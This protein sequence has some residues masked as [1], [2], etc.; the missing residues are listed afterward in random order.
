MDKYIEKMILVSEE[1]W[2]LLLKNE[3]QNETHTKESLFP[4]E[5]KSNADKSETD[6]ESIVNGN[7]DKQ[8]SPP[9]IPEEGIS[10]IDG[11]S[12]EDESSWDRKRKKRK[13]SVENIKTFQSKKLP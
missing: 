8:L 11:A 1:R 2:N 7:E 3:S 5:S 12:F 6:I 13:L 9:G 4:I 10:D